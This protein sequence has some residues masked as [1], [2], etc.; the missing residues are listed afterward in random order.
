MAVRS[1]S[2]LPIVLLAAAPVAAQGG[3]GAAT[4]GDHPA[5]LLIQRQDRVIRFDSTGAGMIEL[6]ARIVVEDEAGVRALGELT[7]AYD[8]ATESIHVDTV[9]VAQVNGGGHVGAT[10][11]AVQD[12]AEP[13]VSEAPTFSDLRE[14]VVTVPGLHPGDTLSY[15]ITWTVRPIVP[16]EFW[17]EAPFTR[18]AAIGEQLTTLDVPRGRILHLD[19]PNGPKPTQTDSG[20]HRLYRWRW[21]NP[22]ADTAATKPSARALLRVSTF[23]DWASVGRWYAELERGREEP[24]DAIRKKARELVTGEPTLRDSISAVYRFVSQNFRYVSLSFGVGR[25]QPHLAG[26]VLANAYG[27]CKDKHTLFAS[28]LKSIGVGSNPVLINEAEDPDSAI[29]SPSQFDH[30]ITLVPLG[31][32]SLWLDTTPD[33]SPFGFLSYGLRGRLALVV[34]TDGRGTLMRTPKAMPFSSFEHV[35]VTGRIGGAGGF[36]GSVEYRLRGS[37]ETAL[38]GVLRRVPATRWDA[39]AKRLG[40]QVPGGGTGSNLS[41]SPIEAIRDPFSISYDL[42]R[43]AS[44]NWNAG[45][46]TYQVP[47]PKVDLEDAEAADDTIKL[48]ANAEETREASLELPARMSVKLPL[49][50]SITRDFASYQ[51]TYLTIRDTVR[52][53]RVLRFL[54]D[55]IPPR[56]LPEWEA[57]KRTIRDDE[58]Q[59]LEL[60]RADGNPP[61][62]TAAVAGNADQL[63]S[64]ALA[65]LNSGDFQRAVVLFHQVLALQPDHKF[66]WNNLGRAFLDLNQLDSASAA[67]RKEI[68]INP[69]DQYSYNNLGLAQWRA[70]NL[71]GAVASFQKQ[72]EI[73]PLDRFSHENLGRIDLVLNRDSDAVA[74]LGKAVVLDPRNGTA[75]A[76]YGRAWLRVH[77]PDSAVAEFDRA[78]QY[79]PTP[80]TWNAIAYALAL[81]GDRLDRAET[82]ARSAVDA[83][84][85]ALR[86]L[87]PEAIT[88]RESGEAQAL[89]SYWDTYGWILFREGK[90]K[91]GEPYVRAAWLLV[92]HGEI[93]DHL[94]QIYESEGKRD[95]ARR[96][97]ALAINAAL[98]VPESRGHLASLVGGDSHVDQW[99]DSGRVWLQEE[100]TVHL[101]AIHGVEGVGVLRV[102]LSPGPT[103]Q[104]IRVV[105]GPAG[106][107]SLA[108]Q[109]RHAT[110]PVEFPD[111]ASVKLPIEG[112]ASCST[113]ACSWVLVGGGPTQTV[114]RAIVAPVRR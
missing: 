46:A 1:R 41:T 70:G 40:D 2:L 107:A 108:A 53:S 32:D 38:R 102:V 52:I 57:F 89:G 61:P 63:N 81:S 65:A 24:T 77:Q 6:G 88:P 21:S 3:G 42:R 47:L 28:L 110:L 27:D 83:T 4:P 11:G 14:K 8:S 37:G 15:H 54:V 39:L 80:T 109:L 103:I 86:A 16:G 59:S 10:P 12:L 92:R 100:R 22:Q 96:L 84:V 95:Q 112:L 33:V 26:D 113:D 68:G 23:A 111:T 104:D 91:E 48:E 87:D 114:T 29:P 67:F 73:N 50:V 69:Y 20:A 99:A 66:A 45:I 62:D 7:F 106:L 75:H 17:Y 56:R 9:W 36:T 79:S 60:L 44:E 49:P 30:L 43:S 93:A 34:G 98:S 18:R 101:K 105:T 85:A 35:K 31:K 97:F 76:D 82:Y 78:V 19:T 72:I 64:Q 5:I 90:V 25:Y 94:G 13:G 74:E 58:T 51:S 55:A 71:T